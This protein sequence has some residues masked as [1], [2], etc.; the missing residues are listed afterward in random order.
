MRKFHKLFDRTVKNEQGQSVVEFMIILPCMM[1]ILVMAIEIGWLCLN[2]IRLSEAAGTAAAANREALRSRAGKQTEAYLEEYYSH[3]V[4]SRMNVK[5]VT[6]Q[7]TCYYDEYIWKWR[8]GK[9]W[10][11]PMKFE[12]LKTDVYLDYELHFLTTFGTA[13][14]KGPVHLNANS[15]AYYVMDHGL[16][17]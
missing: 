15:T 12:T 2:N 8:Q 16:V 5:V 6:S 13:L 1:L 7:D 4:P 10:K 17:K 9:F 11:V 14:F 3:F